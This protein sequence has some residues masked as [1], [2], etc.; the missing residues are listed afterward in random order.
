M[1]E[2][3]PL[4]HL[5]FDHIWCNNETAKC[6]VLLSV[7]YLF[8]FMFHLNLWTDYSFK[9]ILIYK[10]RKKLLEF[11]RVEQPSKSIFKNPINIVI[12]KIFFNNSKSVISRYMRIIGE[13][14]F[15]TR[16]F[17]LATKIASVLPIDFSSNQGEPNEVP[18]RY[19]PT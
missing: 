10:F 11:I 16:L 3:N 5:I 18:H 19:G 6:P 17:M 12:V 8:F 9:P 7:K 13:I 1:A 2:K 14:Y 15:K 4:R